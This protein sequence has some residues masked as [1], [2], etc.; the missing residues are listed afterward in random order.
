V[1]AISDPNAPAL[2]GIQINIPRPKAQPPELPSVT[3]APAESGLASD[4]LTVVPPMPESLADMGI[5]PSVIEQL[6]LK[7][8]YFRGEVMGRDLASLLGVQFSLI[9]E[10]L[11]TLKRQHHVGVK[12]SLGM[13]NN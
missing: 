7:F 5:P 6:V 2:G 9:D 11:E 4:D 10:L 8:L 13:G 12:K 1:S 3:A